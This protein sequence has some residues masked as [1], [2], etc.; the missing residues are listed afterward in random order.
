MPDS[1]LSTR[2]RSCSKVGKR[3]TL[4]RRLSCQQLGSP[5]HQEMDKYLQY[6]P[7]PKVG[8]V[9]LAQSQLQNQ[10]CDQGWSER[11]FTPINRPLNQEAVAALNMYA[12]SISTSKQSGTAKD[13]ARSKQTNL[14]WLLEITAFLSAI[15][16]TQKLSE[17]RQESHNSTHQL[18]LI[19][20]YGAW[21]P[22]AV[23]RMRSLRQSPDH[24]TKPGRPKSQKVCFVNMT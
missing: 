17:K 19:D 5:K 9:M 13:R 6:R 2:T 12:P 1:V 18:D 15:V 14:R 7:K 24:Q 21:R 10:E 11:R 20:I 3:E 22:T 4:R 8:A 16:R 23:E